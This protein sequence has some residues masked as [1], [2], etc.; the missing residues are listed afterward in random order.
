LRST[1]TLLGSVLLL[2][3]SVCFMFLQLH[4][5]PTFSPRGCLLLYS[6]SLGPV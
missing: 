5:T 1:S 6:H 3:M 2:V 4:S